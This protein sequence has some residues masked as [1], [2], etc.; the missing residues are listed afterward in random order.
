[1]PLLCKKGVK[2]KKITI[3]AM[4]IISLFM[5]VACTVAEPTPTEI[6]TILVPGAFDDVKNVLV[7][8]LPRSYQQQ[9]HF[10]KSRRLSDYLVYG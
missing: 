7:E 4:L 9:F 10:A 1:M 6:D 5:L 2:M 3:L 8:Q